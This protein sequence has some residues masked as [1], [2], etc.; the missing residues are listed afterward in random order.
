MQR[1]K[2][3]ALG[4]F[5][6]KILSVS[7]L[8]VSIFLILAGA[9]FVNLGFSGF[10]LL[11]VIARYN[12]YLCVFLFIISYY[13]FSTAIH[14]HCEVV[15]DS[16]MNKRNVWRNSAAIIVGFIC[17][18]YNISLI[19]I[20]LIAALKNDGSHYFVG[21]FWKDYAYNV[22]I[23][24]VICIGMSYV[25][26]IVIKYSSILA[27][28]MSLLFILMISPMAEL[29]VWMQKPKGIPYDCIVNIVRLPF[30]ILY[31]NS[32]W[33]PDAQ[34][35][36]QTEHRRLLI[37]L[38]WIT[39]ILIVALVHTM[40]SYLKN[41]IAII[42]SMCF[43]FSV[44]SIYQPCSTYRLKESWNGIYEDYNYYSKYSS[45]QEVE[46]ETSDWKASE[47]IL[48]IDINKLL[49]VNGT[50]KVKVKEAKD[51][52]DTFSFTLYHGYN[53]NE[54][55]INGEKADYTRQEDLIIC[56]L[57][58]SVSELDVYIEYAGYSNKYYSN[59]EGV[60][61]PGYFAWYPMPGQKSVYTWY[62][63]DY[64]GG[65][66]YNVYNRV[67][68]SD[69]N[70]NINCDSQIIC[71][72]DTTIS[73]DKDNQ[74]FSGTSDSITLIG[75]N[76]E[77]VEGSVIKNILPLL[78]NNGEDTVAEYEQQYNKMI[79]NLQTVWGIDSD[80]L[81][82]KKIIFSSEE[83]SRN[84]SNNYISVYSNYIL[85][86]QSQL[87]SAEYIN[88]KIIESNKKSNLANLLY[89][90]GMLLNDESLTAKSLVAQLIS[91]SNNRQLS[92]KELNGT[93][94]EILKDVS[95]ELEQADKFIGS[96]KFVKE[97]VQYLLTD[98][99]I[100]SDYEF[101]EYLKAKYNYL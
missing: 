8:V 45:T 37:Q 29:L 73:E 68:P 66:G 82:E 34:S 91:D 101:F 5:K 15:I 98:N 39:L 11:Y 48:N 85:L 43:I 24:Q 21:Y 14:S 97:L 53:I 35:G 10:M 76:V 70:L 90:T 49:K 2:F 71:N 36:L 52:K 17:A 54:L 83:L 63:N 25:F 87:S 64:A 18:I 94:D 6:N 33:S 62:H 57:E 84:N 19:I 40:N 16:C 93:T 59:S 67:E 12:F 47:Y 50:F 23:P 95:Y 20:L 4:F 42:L 69:F 80:D 7:V 58:K 28:M 13:F 46:T 99:E 74:K 3:L 81:K 78:E 22:L 61:L 41:V 96:E 100:D 30:E 88:Y 89:Y 65:Y 86:P 75:G 32:D 55:V 44:I 27:S 60:M 79:Y 38:I 92:I 26:S 9:F 51:T 72:L 31:Q 77:S 56:N 1:I